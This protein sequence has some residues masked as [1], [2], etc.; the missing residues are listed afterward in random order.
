MPGVGALAS[1]AVAEP[2]VVQPTAARVAQQVQHAI[3]TRWIVLAEPLLEELPELVRQSQQHERRSSR[4]GSGGRVEQA[5]HLVV[6]QRGNHRRKQHAHRHAGVRKRPDDPQPR[7]RRRRARL[8]HALERVVERGEADEDGD[9][10]QSCEVREQ[11]EVAQHE[12]ALGH[13]GDRVAMHEQHFEQ[14]SRR[15]VLALRGLVRIGIGA[16]IDRLADVSGCTQLAV[17]QPRKPRLVKDARLEIEPG[18]QV[19]VGVGRP[20]EAIDAAVLAA[21]VWVYG[22]VERNVRRLVASDRVTRDVGSQ[23]RFHSSGRFLETAP[24]VVGGLELRAFEPARRVRDRAAPLFNLCPVRPAHEAR[25]LYA[26]TAVTAWRR[27]SDPCARAPETVSS[28]LRQRPASRTL[29]PPLRARCRT[30]P[31]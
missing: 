12:R 2:G 25:I 5:L 11:V 9:E 1:H 17:Q 19:P 31:R 29:P 13:D 8:E 23:D 3:R 20:R 21:L 10:A 6:V 15:A 30:R 26:Y 16:E 28:R 18:T 14:L 4:P 7:R 24:P 22:L 27:G